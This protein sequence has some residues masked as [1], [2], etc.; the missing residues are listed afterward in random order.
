MSTTDCCPALSSIGAASRR[1]RSPGGRASTTITT[2]RCA[3]NSDA[4]S[5]QVRVRLPTYADNAALP[6]F[7][8][9]RCCCCNRSRSAHRAH[10][11]KPA[12]A[13]P[14]QF[15]SSGFAAMGPRWD[16]RTTDNVP[17]SQTM[18]RILRG[19]RQQCAVATHYVLKFNVAQ[20]FTELN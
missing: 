10:S 12:A 9:R 20:I 8:R 2:R 7:A 1:A 18:L 19:Q 6:A 5:K 15:C 14:R 3:Y 17:S 11:S 13:V 16:R 4:R